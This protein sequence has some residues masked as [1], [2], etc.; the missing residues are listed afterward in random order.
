MM[1]RLAA[2]GG[3]RPYM[4]PSIF[5]LFYVIGAN[6]SALMNITVEGPGRSLPEGRCRYWCTH[7]RTRDHACCLRLPVSGQ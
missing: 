3:C 7:T 2:V 1:R 4:R 6:E 5:G